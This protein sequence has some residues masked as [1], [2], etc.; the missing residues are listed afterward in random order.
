MKNLKTSSPVSPARPSWRMAGNELRYVR[1]VLEG[2]FPGSSSVN[3]T[4]RLETAFA[5][6]FDCEYAITFNN[7]TATLHAALAAVGVTPGDEVIVPPLTMAST[8]LAVLHQGATPVFADIDP[9]TFTLDPAK[10]RERITPRTKAI[11]P[12]ALYGLSPDLDAIMAI[13]REHRLAVIE[14]DAQCFL[15]RYQGRMVGALG[16]LASF[17]FQNSKHLTC[18][19]GG[20]V[21]TS[22]P[23]Y[24]ER[25]RRFSSLGYGLVSAKPGASKIDKKALV[26]PTFKRHM[27]LG[28]NY[29]MSELCAAVAF[30][31]LER[32]EEFVHWR[33]KTAAAFQEAIGSCN[34]L[35]TPKTPAGYEHTYWAYPILLDTDAVPWEKFYD[36]F[37]QHGGDG[38]Y[39]AWSLNYLEPIFQN[40]IAGRYLEGLCPVA[41]AIQ[42]RLMQFKTHYGDDVT[43]AQQAAAL[44]QTISYFGR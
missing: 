10:I 14:D 38:F 13:A 30:A 20:M 35:K 40:G 44:S 18:G 32:L 4:G 33:R 22:N 2:G 42:P 43:I 21:T 11:M 28:F 8:A 26:R 12:V 27:A 7:G 29:R 15:G 41:E 23:E 34:W 6:K 3:F 31:Q 25:V 39:G 36:A 5:Q 17:S 9:E 24:A 1:E 16:D 19:E 37:Q